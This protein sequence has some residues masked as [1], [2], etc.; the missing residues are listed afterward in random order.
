MIKIL[1]TYKRLVNNKNDINFESVFKSLL[2]KYSQ[3]P[4][5]KDLLENDMYAF[6][7][8]NVF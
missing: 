1:Y 2:Q 6:K 5:V 8:L 7:V 4:T 3:S